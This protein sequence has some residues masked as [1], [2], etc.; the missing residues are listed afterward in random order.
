M[1]NSVGKFIRD[2]IFIVRVLFVLVVTWLG[3]QIGADKAQGDEGGLTTAYTIVCF[4]LASFFVVV[5]YSTGIIS[6]KKI[7]LSSFGL[8]LGLV[9]AKLIYIEIPQ[10]YEKILM[11]NWQG[12]MLCNLLFGFIGV[13]LA[14]KHAA[15]FDA[16]KLKFIV[17]SPASE[18]KIL[19]TSV[20]IDGRIRELIFGSFIKGPFMV[21]EFVID[22]LQKLAD[23]ADS[24][25][26]AKGRRGLE[27]LDTLQESDADLTIV[28]KDYP[29]IPAVDQKLL[30][31]AQEIGGV[32]LTND[33]N[34]DKV[35]QLHDVRVMNLNELASVMKPVTYVG[36]VMVLAISKEGKEPGQGVG[37][38]EDGTMVVIEEGV[39]FIGS[40][41]E[42]VVVS[43]LHTS[44]GRMIFAKLHNASAAQ[45]RKRISQQT[46]K[47]EAIKVGKKQE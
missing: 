31:L 12:Q 46:A 38:L 13:I 30:R 44:G 36:E 35:A 9:V 5:E 16:S 37:Y 39:N 22:E 24:A 14:L 43:I 40:Q 10:D 19:D 1:V 15:Y 27:V 8:L 28:D 6:S 2:E 23:S 7:L 18:S 4:L 3:L 41:V 21:P 11:T 45:G 29:S 20:I 34:L 25:K 17:S 47:I 33:F 26:R 32:L 42:V